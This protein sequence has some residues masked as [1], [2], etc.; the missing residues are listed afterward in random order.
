MQIDTVT[1]GLRRSKRHAESFQSVQ[2]LP[3]ASA[4]QVSERSRL[5][6]ES[7]TGFAALKNGELE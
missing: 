1:V 2:E 7:V 6:L 5:S 4:R 3:F